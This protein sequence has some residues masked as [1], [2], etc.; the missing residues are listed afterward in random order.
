MGAAT[1]YGKVYNDKGEV[2]IAVLMMLKGN[3]LKKVNCRCKD[4]M[5]RLKKCCLKVNNDRTFLDRTKWLNNT[6]STVEKIY[7][8]AR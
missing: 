3:Q 5:H 6:I 1:R 2:A 8:K 4:K 7:W